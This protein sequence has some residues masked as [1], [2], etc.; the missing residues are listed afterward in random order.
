MCVSFLL[1]SLNDHLRTYVWADVIKRRMIR[2]RLVPVALL[3]FHSIEL[4]VYTS[5]L[6]YVER[7][8]SYLPFGNIE[9]TH[10]RTF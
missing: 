1:A 8:F 2:V 6:D 4:Q 7:L 5:T 3:N 10:H 9:D